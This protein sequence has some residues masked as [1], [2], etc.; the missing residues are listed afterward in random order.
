M[1]HFSR[2]CNASGNRLSIVDTFVYLGSK[3]S[4]DGSLDAEIY[5]RI[6]KASIAFGKLEKRVLA[7][8]D[9]T[10]NIKIII[11]KNCVITVLLY[12]DETWT[13]C[14]RHIKLHE[15]F[16]QKCLKRILNIKCA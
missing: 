16:H 7:D 4:K 13:A 10:I 1:D 3:V 15:R 9:I 5:L 14:K 11:Y 8:R 12:S 2:V 6:S